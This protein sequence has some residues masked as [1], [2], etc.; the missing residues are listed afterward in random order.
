MSFGLFST[1]LRMRFDSSPQVVDRG[2]GSLLESGETLRRLLARVFRRR[3][4]ILRVDDPL[5][6]GLHFR[7]KLRLLAL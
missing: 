7:P 4:R 5:A 3:R 2:F 6:Q 1:D